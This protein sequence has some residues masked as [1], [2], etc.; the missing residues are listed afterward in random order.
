[1]RSIPGKSI[2]TLVVAMLL[3]TA[4]PA[5]AGDDLPAKGAFL[6]ASPIPNDDGTVTIY[7][8]GIGTHIG[9]STVVA[10]HQ[11]CPPDFNTFTMGFQALSIVITAANG[12]TL[13]ATASGT[14]DLLTGTFTETITISGGTGRF[15]NAQGT[16]TGTGA[17]LDPTGAAAETFTGTISGIGG[18]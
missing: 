18:N 5:T 8:S 17:L 9:N 10:V 4:Y 2:V 12:D 16:L 3:F 15:T 6:F 11:N 7:G 13:N 14:I 1:M